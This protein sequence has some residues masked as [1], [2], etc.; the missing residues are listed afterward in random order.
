[1]RL[2]RAVRE[3]NAEHG[4]RTRVIA[5]HTEAERRASF[6]R[7]A[8]EAVQLRET[9]AG[10]PYLDHDEL[11]RALRVARADAAWVGWGFVAE[12]P[13]FAELCASLGVTFIGPPPEAMRLLGAKIEAK[14]LAE[15]TGVPV[16]PWSGGPVAGIDDGRRH[17]A[18]IGYPLIVKSRSGGGGRGIRIVRSEA[19]LEEALERTTAEAAR[20]FG[21]PVIFMERLVEGGRHVEVQVI[22]DQHGTVWAPGVRDC[23]VQRR[24]QK[25]IEESSSPALTREQDA[26]LRESAKAL[27]KAAGYVNAGT[28]EFLYQPTEKLFTFLEVNTR[29]QVEHPVT[30][31]T[32]GL[33]IVKLQIHV[34]S[35]GRL[36][37]EPPSEFGHAIE[38][39]LNAE[40]AEQ[41]FAPAPGTVE[42]MRLPTG[43]GVR[44]DTGM[45][46]G[47]V[48]PPAYDSMVA[49]VIA[50]GRDRPEALARL[51]CALRDTTVVLRGGTTT[52][53]FLLDLLDRP[54]VV[55]GTAD[56]GWLDR[57]GTVTS[58]RPIGHAWAAL[59]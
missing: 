4:T 51:R 28:V 20:T 2:T 50:W 10:S 26:S 58:P 32:T 6:V 37:G 35:G 21:D 12:D 40:D 18:T 15:Q 43:P 9:G 11:A 42:F 29:L 34:A 17:A 14:V 23:S 54:E 31:A 33:D 39:R 46:V 7:A 55:A 16:A 44:V 59:V 1:M 53:S 47:D 3:L 56:T 13:T 19:E 25:V 30:E 48:I 38:A 8:D 49:K 45:T 41:E 5:L 36:E 24:N 52:K 22:A 57:T 27:V